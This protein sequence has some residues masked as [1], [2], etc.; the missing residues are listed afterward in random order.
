MDAESA[1]HSSSQSQVT[2]VSVG[3]MRSRLRPR[4]TLGSTHPSVP[5]T[6]SNGRRSRSQATQRSNRKGKGKMKAPAVE[7]EHEWNCPVSGCGR[8]HLSLLM[9]GRWTMDEKRGA[10]AV[11]V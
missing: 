10:I 9:D 8:V 7:A 11:F 2:D 5:T 1:E 4:R 3:S 6:T